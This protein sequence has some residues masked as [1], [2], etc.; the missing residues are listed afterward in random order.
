[1]IGDAALKIHVVD[2]LLLHRELRDRQRGGRLRILERAAS[3]RSQVQCAG[4]LHVARAQTLMLLQV[5]VGRLQ[6]SIVT[7]LIGIESQLALRSAGA[8]AHEQGQ[9]TFY[10]K[11]EGYDA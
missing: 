1:M 8:D 3:A 7:F 4:D 2:L 9:L 5:D 10:P 6:D 11:Q